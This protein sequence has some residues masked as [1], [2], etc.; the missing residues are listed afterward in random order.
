MRGESAH[1]RAHGRDQRPTPF[2]AVALEDD[3][4]GHVHAAALARIA[5]PD[6]RHQFRPRQVLPGLGLGEPEALYDDLVVDD[7]EAGHG[8]RVPG[9]VLVVERNSPDIRRQHSQ[10]LFGQPAGLE[11]P[12]PLQFI[13]RVRSAAEEEVHADPVRLILELG[14][15]VL[16]D[17]RG[18]PHVEPFEVYLP[19]GLL[20]VKLLE[21]LPE[22]EAYPLP[23]R[24]EDGQ[25]VLR[26]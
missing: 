21:R 14:L 26:A 3:L 19:P 1:V 18:A 2:P 8:G 24:R 15:D 13:I 16:Q 4:V 23:V 11:E 7:P 12:E 6:P 5:G 25:L 9:K 10:G 20:F 22:L 17:V